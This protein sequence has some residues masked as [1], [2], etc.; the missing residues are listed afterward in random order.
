MILIAP[1][2]TGAALV[3][4]ASRPGASPSCLSTAVAI[5]LRRNAAFLVS[6][7]GLLTGGVR[8][9]SASSPQGRSASSARGG[10][11]GRHRC[12]DGRGWR[13]P[14]PLPALLFVWGGVVGALYTVGLAHLGARFTGPDHSS[15]NAAFVVRLP[16]SA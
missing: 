11:V 15:A 16:M 8:S 6:L 12:G 5:G 13:R 14:D 4:G 3:F 9:L 1:V 2:A 7:V 10:D